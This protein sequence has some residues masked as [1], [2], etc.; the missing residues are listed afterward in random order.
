MAL[1]KALYGSGWLICIANRKL[2][3]AAKRSPYWSNT[4]LAQLHGKLLAYVQRKQ[5]EK[6]VL[7]RQINWYWS[8]DFFRNLEGLILEPLLIR[9]YPQ[10][11]EHYFEYFRT[12]IEGVRSCIDLGKIR[13][14]K[15]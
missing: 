3:L 14:G 11:H 6:R 10:F 1:H 13:K 15:A 9:S 8:E 4:E 12:T 7:Q 2:R 5:M